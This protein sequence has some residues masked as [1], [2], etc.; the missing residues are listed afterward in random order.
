MGVVVVVVVLGGSGGMGQLAAFRY[1]MGSC[2]HEEVSTITLATAV[3][4][5]C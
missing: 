4:L 5:R 1:S 3:L 2:C